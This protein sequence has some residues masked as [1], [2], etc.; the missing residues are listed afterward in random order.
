[1]SA[2]DLRLALV[3]AGLL[4]AGCGRTPQTLDLLRAHVGAEEWRAEPRLDLSR[5]AGVRRVRGASS[6][7]AGA[8]GLELVGRAADGVVTLELEVRLA[9]ITD[10][11]VRV[12]GRA[13][14]TPCELAVRV[15][16]RRRA[17]GRWD[18]GALELRVPA[19]SWS[20]GRNRIE[21]QFVGDGITPVAANLAAVE[22]LHARQRPPPVDAVRPS[23]ARSSG[24]AEKPRQR[25]GSAVG[26]RGGADGFVQPEGTEW[27]RRAF[28]PKQSSLLVEAWASRA[29]G[30]LTVTLAQDGQSTR[31]IGVLEMRGDRS[32]RHQIELEL[33]EAGPVELA[34]RFAGRQAA[35]LH[36]RRMNLAC[37]PSARFRSRTRDQSARPHVV[38]VLVDTVRPDRLST[39]GHVR[40]TSPEL[41]RLAREGLHF[42]AARSNASWTRAAVA[43]LFTGL[44]A[45]VHRVDGHTSALAQRFTTLAERFHRAGYRTVAASANAGVTARFGFAQGFDRFESGWRRGERMV[46]YA[47][48]ELARARRPTLVYLHLMEPHYPYRPRARYRSFVPAYRGPLLNRDRF[49]HLATHGELELDRADLDY[50]LGLYDGE[51]AEADACLGRLLDQLAARGLA[52]RSA[53]LYLADHGEEFADHGS[54]YHGHSLYEELLAVPM[55]LRLP[56]FER[57]GQAIVEPVQTIDL[58]PTLLAVAGLEIPTDLPGRS[59]LEWT[60][61]VLAELPRPL[62]AETRLGA[63]L[64]SV[65]LGPWKLIA[66]LERRWT[67]PRAFRLYHLGRDPR[68]QRDLSAQAPI[69]LDLLAGLLQAREEAWAR[70]GSN[71]GPVERPLTAQEEEE[72][73]ALGYL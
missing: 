5:A 6:C 45:A 24:P 13:G 46:D 25:R 7:V 28:L 67:T 23:P 4:A 17:R 62:F 21:F 47:I 52:H 1:M 22:L 71:G 30:W 20:E 41:S 11:I 10:R 15:G 70:L 38:V 31:T 54:F 61:G 26:V 66:A 33:G 29:G 14:Q 19:A 73:R 60:P 27:V 9:R 42:L 43:S 12:S 63:K 57:A 34:F 44:E 58:L 51:L 72:L 36:W 50:V 40:P 32:V 55:V 65:R 68:E 35:E 8:A 2:R 53:V 16:G 49:I 18:G 69:A 3:S 59:L 37:P 64:R 48:E 39:Y 56:G